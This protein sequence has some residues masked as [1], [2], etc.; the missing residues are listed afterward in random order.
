MPKNDFFTTKLSQT[1]RIPKQM[2]LLDTYRH[3]LFGL[4]KIVFICCPLNENA[5]HL[6][7]LPISNFFVSILTKLI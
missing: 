7:T 1:S 2:K 6:A 4:P 3:F 5:S